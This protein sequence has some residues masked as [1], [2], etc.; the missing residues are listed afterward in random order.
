M[1]PTGAPSPATANAQSPSRAPEP[2]R[3]RRLAGP[4]VTIAGLAVA[5]VSLHFR[6][7]HVGGS[8]GLCPSAAI[9]GVYCPGCGGLRAVHDL[10]QGDL[11]GAASSNLLFFVSVPLILFLL[12]RWSW[13]AWH[14][15]DRGRTWLSSKPMLW[16]GTAIVLAFAVARNSP[17]G[18]WLAP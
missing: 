12:G 2:S 18:S 17:V 5:T 10:T 11:G 15:I 6:D 14:G 3:R 9:L 4:A 7:P 8:W 1:T 13:D 16:A